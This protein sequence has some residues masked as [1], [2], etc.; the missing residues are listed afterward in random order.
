MGEFLNSF[1]NGANDLLRNK[2]NLISLLVLGILILALPLGI[3]LIR[4]Q[5]ILRSRAG[6]DPIV[7]T[8]TNVEQRNGK[9]IVLDPKQPIS[10]QLTSPLDPPGVPTPSQSPTSPPATACGT[11]A[12]SL[13]PSAGS[14][15]LNQN[16]EIDVK[17]IPGG[18]DITAVEF[19]LN[20]VSDSLNV[21]SIAQ[22]SN[23]FE[24]A[25]VGGGSSAEGGRHYIFTRTP[26]STLSQEVIIGKIFFKP[27]ATAA[28]STGVFVNIVGIAGSGGLPT[29]TVSGQGNLPGT[30]KTVTS[31]TYDIVP[32]R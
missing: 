10:L 8:G 22:G 32:G 13:S 14:I 2:K 18:C 29:I 21:A 26:R 31:G 16:N 9:W 6:V 30:Q 5:Q 27:P 19:G 11:V 20:Y 23:V 1:K 24:M 12:L 25:E 17:L 28:A 7:F 4:Q 15:S 3:N